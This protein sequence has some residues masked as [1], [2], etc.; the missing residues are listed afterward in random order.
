MPDARPRLVQPR[1]FDLWRTLLVAST[2]LGATVWSLRRHAPT[3]GM[4]E[5]SGEAQGTWYHVRVRVPPRVAGGAVEE[6]V[7]QALAEA[8]GAFSLWN[9][10]SEIARFNRTPAGE[11]FESSPGFHRVATLARDLAARTSGAFDPTLGTVLRRWGFGPDTPARPPD[12]VELSRAL[13]A[14]GWRDWI[15]D[16]GPPPA[17][18][19]R[20]EG[21]ELDLNAVAQGWTVDR[22]AARLRALG[23]RDFMVEVGGELYAAGRNAAGRRW[24]I[25]IDQPRAETLP[26]ERLAGVLQ[27]S[28]LAVATSGGYRRQRRDAAG[29]PVTHVFDGRTGRAVPRAGMS[30][31]V[32]ADDCVTADGLSTVLLILGPDE[33]LRWLER[34]F[35]DADALFLEAPPEDAVLRARR[36]RRFDERTSF[37]PLAPMSPL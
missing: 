9:T 26:G 33:G 20:R 12:D 22:I 28:D 3:G 24:R 18:I 6:G 29:R 14:V 8:D 15:L 4:A 23:A 35:P 37:E 16:E 2:V 27:V 7:H 5:W 17:M 34:E 31:T 25:G 30:V 11:R 32:I 36:S 21:M 19:K 1:R 13:E 10:N